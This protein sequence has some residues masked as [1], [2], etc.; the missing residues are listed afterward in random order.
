MLLEVGIVVAVI[1]IVSTVLLV[2]EDRRIHDET[3][4]RTLSVADQIAELPAVHEALLE[5][6]RQR[7]LRSLAQTIAG[8]ASVDYVVVADLAGVRLTHPDAERIGEA[9]STDHSAIRAGETFVGVEE[10]TLGPT[11]RAKV[12]VIVDD[13]VVGTVSV[14]VLQSRLRGALLDSALLI[15]PWIAAAAVVGAVLAAA[16]TRA[17]RR[18]VYG[19]EPDEVGELLSSRQA[20]LHSVRDGVVAVDAHES[21]VLVNDEARR[22]LGVDE[23]APGTPMAQVLD[24]D[25]VALLRADGDAGEQYVLAGERVLLAARS[26]AVVDGASAGRTLT[27][28]DRT[29]IEHTLREL[30]GQRS[31][32]D[33]LASQSHEFANRLHVISGLVAMDERQALVDYLARLGAEVSDAR[34]PRLG[35]LRLS[36]VLHTLSAQ[37]R[38][39]GIRLD[40]DPAAQV[41]DR[42]ADDEDLVTVVGN[43]VDNAL[44]ATGPGGA[45]RVSVAAD[46]A[47]AHVEVVDDGPGIPP[48]R[49]DEVLRRGVSTKQAHGRRR[50]IGLALVARIAQRRGGAVEIDDAPGGGARVCVRW[51]H[52]AS[53]AVTT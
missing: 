53:V 1:A 2:V 8:A 34:A 49:R 7:E 35:S 16:A 51:R 39:R 6:T 38:E 21:I 48:E 20:L 15:A 28:R 30:E 9:V 41:S 33:A 47:G 31:L 25:L 36:A 52:P 50:G 13:A 40:L 14:G 26:D 17:I 44:D 24:D 27:L 32:A 29:E 23:I 22:L 10:G 11:L 46:E 18:R 4:E 12:P 37:A 45:V 3:S 42:W 5:G 43:L 19:V